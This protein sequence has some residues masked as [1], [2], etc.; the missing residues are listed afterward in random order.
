[1]VTAFL[2]RGLMVAALILPIL[3]GIA[4]GLGGRTFT[5]E[6]LLTVLASR[7]STGTPDISGFGRDVQ[8][9]ELLKVVR[10]EA[11]LLESDDVVRR[12]LRSLGPL[13]LYPG[14]AERRRFGLLPPRPPEEHLDRAVEMFRRD[15]R[16]GTDASSNIL[17]VQFTYSDRAL[18]IRALS[19][20][21]D[22][23]FEQRSELAQNGNSRF[24]VTELDRYAGELQQLEARIVAEKTEAGV[25]DIAQD[26]SL[27]GNRVSGILDRAD[28]VREQLATTQAQLASAR[29]QLAALP[30]RVTAS[31]ESTN[32][33]ANDET[34]NNLARLEQE[35]ARVAALYA[36]GWPGLR[37]LD[38]RIN[39]AR[40]A[41]RATARNAFATRREVRNPEVEL[42]SGRIVTLQVEAAALTEQLVE[43][44]KQ[45][46]AAEARS[47]TLLRAD[48]SLRDLQRRRD[49]LE[50]VYRQ[51]TTRE[52]GT[53]AEEDA[54]RMGNASVQVTQQASAP[55]SGKSLAPA[56]M[57]VGIL[58]GLTAAA[59]VAVALTWLRRSFATP[60]EA[61][62][63]LALPLLASFEPLGKAADQLADNEGIAGLAAQILDL[64]LD[65]RRPQI[66]QLLSSEADDERGKMARLLALEFARARSKETL[67]VDL[68]EDGRS[69][70]AALGTQPMNVE[71]IE[72]HVLAF[73]TVIERL[74]ITYEAQKSDLMNI[75]VDVAQIQDVLA[76]LRRA[77]ELVIV[78]GPDPSASYA[79]RRLAALVDANVMVVH[80][81]STEAGPLRQNRDAVLAA[82]G[83]VL[84]LAFTGRRQVVPRRLEKLVD[85]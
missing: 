61:E 18:A 13:T 79:T 21:L 74:W 15:L 71:R 20:L 9:I 46:E 81:E 51:F 42:L 29:A 27:A 35:R 54:R 66:I 16:T 53:R 83:Q 57:L 37:D 59:G 47:A 60:S 72:G 26:I 24:L 85:A 40:E 68:Q 7:E 30:Q 80:G 38:N 69:H 5:A 6:S 28:R 36:P 52:A 45:R 82:G 77:F 65:G 70:L 58:G 34:R 22:A 50:A 11:G 19:A 73:N 62:R 8:A 84:G 44:E 31:L 56:F 64:R 78:I 1:M 48:A 23:Y 41:V 67:L 12:A 3:A 75:R 10:S 39:A 43:L 55:I 14:L 25:L 17:R 49:G 2:W 4:M 33:V 63:G 32:I 76:Q